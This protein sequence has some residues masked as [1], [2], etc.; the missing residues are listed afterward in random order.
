MELSPKAIRLLID[1]LNHY[2]EHFDRRLE[3]ERL[4]EDE[5]ADLANDQQFLVALRQSLAN[6]HEDLVNSRVSLSN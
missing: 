5:L 2:D 1:A 4:S 3:D 6:H